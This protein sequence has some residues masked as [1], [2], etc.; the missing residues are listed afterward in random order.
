MSQSM[1]VGIYYD[2][3]IQNDLLWHHLAYFVSCDVMSASWLQRLRGVI[4]VTTVMS[5]MYVACRSSSN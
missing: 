3:E 1:A 2:S 4:I 5:V